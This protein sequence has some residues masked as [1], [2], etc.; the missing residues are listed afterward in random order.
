MLTKRLRVNAQKA[1]RFIILESKQLWGVNEVNFI[2]RWCWRDGIGTK[3]HKL[4]K[5]FR[6]TFTAEFW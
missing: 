2:R 5:S 4:F 1:K 6:L 3:R